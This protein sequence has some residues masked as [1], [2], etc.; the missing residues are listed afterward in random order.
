MIGALSLLFLVVWVAVYI[1]LGSDWADWYVY[2][3]KLL[4]LS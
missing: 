3:R 2:R 4:V 1:V